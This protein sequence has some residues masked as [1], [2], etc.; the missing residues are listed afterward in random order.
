MHMPSAEEY[1]RNATECLEVA[2]RMTLRTERERMFDMAQQ[3]L[4]LAQKAEA[5]ESAGLRP[6]LTR[7]RTEAS[8]SHLPTTRRGGDDGEEKKADSR[9]RKQDRAA[10]PVGRSMKS[11]TRQRRRASQNPQ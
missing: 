11:A 2:K 9:G 5:E 8:K 6:P 3:W 7:T 4:E 10:S 1:R